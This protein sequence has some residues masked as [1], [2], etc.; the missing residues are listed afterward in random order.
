MLK[1]FIPYAYAKNIYDIDIEFYK[2]LNIKIIF[3]DLDNTLDPYFRLVPSE[4]AHE[5][6]KKLE[7]N[8]IK[9]VVVSNNTKTRVKRYA[10]QLGCEFISSAR[11]PF[12]MKTRKYI[13]NGNISKNDCLIIGDQIFTD[14]IFGNRLKIKTILC[15]NLVSKDQFFTKFNKFFDR[16]IRKSLFKRKKM[17]FWE[18][19]LNGKTQ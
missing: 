18:D 5:L 10:D 9:L 11:K 17:I 4:A 8:N 2:A 15:D 16:F 7:E 19:R 13:K 1:V 14:V 3:C 6:S 12:T